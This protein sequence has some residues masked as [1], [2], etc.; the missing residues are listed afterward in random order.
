VNR[1]R[2]KRGVEP[3]EEPATRTQKDVA[4]RA[5]DIVLENPNRPRELARELT[6]RPR[7][8]TDLEAAILTIER[9]NL[10]KAR[11]QADADGIAAAKRGDLDA[12]I[13]AKTRAAQASDDFMA[14]DMATKGSGTE[15]A[16]G[17]AMRAREMAED[18]SLVAM[19]IARRRENNYKPLTERQA[20]ETKAL[21]DRLA[22]ALAE[23]DAYR[24]QVE[25]AKAPPAP[26]RSTSRKAPPTLKSPAY[27]A[28]NR[29]VT[30]EA[31]EATKAAM[32]AKMSRMSAGIDPTFI[33]DL[34]KI[35][36][37]HVEAGA[38]NFGAW[39]KVMVDDLGEKVRPH[40]RAAWNDAKRQL[41]PD[42]LAEVNAPILRGMKTRAKS[43][44]ADYEARVATGR[45]ETPE[46]VPVAKDAE[47]IRLEARA[48]TAKKAWHEAL[49]GDRLRNRPLPKKVGS[50]AADIILSVPRALQTAGDVSAVL[51]QAGMAAFAHPIR[52]AKAVPEMFR[53]MFSEAATE[54]SAAAI[55]MDPNYGNAVRAG[56]EFTE[57]GAPLRLS[58]MEEAYRSRLAEKIPIIGR[59][60][61]KPSQRSF[62]TFLNRVRLES[63][64]ALEATLTRTGTAT[65]AEARAL[66]N[67]VNV[68]N[69]RGNVGRFAGAMDAA[70]NVLYSPRN[71]ISRFQILAGQPLYGGSARTR[72][73]IAKEYG[74]YLVGLGVLYGMANLSG[75]ADV[76]LDPRSSD[77]LKIRL[78]NTRLDPLSGLAQV[79]TF[80]GR[81]VSGETKDSAGKVREV[82]FD[83]IS[84]FA[85]TK[86]APTLGA[87]IDL[88]SG[89]NV[90]GEEATLGS[91]ARQ[92]VTPLSVDEIV[93][94]M[95]EHGVPKGAAMGL[96]SLFGM[97][98]QTYEAK[99]GKRGRRVAPG[100]DNRS[101][102]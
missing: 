23:R 93:K 56:V 73:L 99:N 25:A 1:E 8:H 71:L 81:M 29:L 47:A 52:T 43:R 91:T 27:G 101:G 76:E 24:F 63:Y 14:L 22:Q 4:E 55:R 46:R 77:F 40:L 61:V 34:A 68:F 26:E 80:I 9:V 60:I 86:A 70:A 66:A 32:R 87:A 59:F 2:A 51:R 7:A 58:Q 38:R 19:E 31:Y 57:H 36:A 102:R 54:R 69:G 74:R 90:V 96:L 41:P 35:G 10:R 5:F 49:L 67:M 48:E 97:G 37:F 98:L 88:R 39:A 100:S 72:A 83:D 78:G 85:R 3:M 28:T 82:R 65:P 30:R 11:A 95:D 79:S 75:E 12:I 33:A 45:L 6:E 18:Y 92:L 84:R 42:V 44:T 20:A 13:E 53:S 16:R 62:T 94:A 15:T 17:L 64:N 21:H 89:K 50:F